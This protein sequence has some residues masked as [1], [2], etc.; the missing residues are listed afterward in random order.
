MAELFDT[1]LEFGLKRLLFE[2]IF[3]R[4]KQLVDKSIEKD[5]IDTTIKQ[6]D[7]TLEDDNIDFNHT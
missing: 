4:L 5:K 3:T 1:G 6:E 7:A 2:P